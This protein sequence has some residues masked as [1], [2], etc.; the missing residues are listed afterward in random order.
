MS[1]ALL[2]SGA[3]K[4][5]RTYGETT[6]YGGSSLLFRVNDLREYMKAHYGSGE[7]V[8]SKSDVSGRTG[9]L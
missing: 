8:D 9:I 6:G 1:N 4:D 7:I 3:T 2:K 5:M